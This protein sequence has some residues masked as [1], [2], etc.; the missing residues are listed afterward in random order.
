MQIHLPE[1][2]LLLQICALIRTITPVELLLGESHRRARLYEHP[3]RTV[4]RF[5]DSPFSEIPFFNHV[6]ICVIR[7]NFKR[8]IRFI[9]SAPFN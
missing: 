7:D 2:E 5:T 4:A 8:T 1:G 9:T 3:T 6:I